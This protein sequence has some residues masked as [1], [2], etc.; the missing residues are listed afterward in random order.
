MK[1]E[2]SNVQDNLK[3][4]ISKWRYFKM[5]RNKKLF[6]Y[7]NTRKDQVTKNFSF[8]ITPARIK[9]GKFTLRV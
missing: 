9:Y 6:I 7:N 5:E 1:I 8:I 2:L 4:G 3:G